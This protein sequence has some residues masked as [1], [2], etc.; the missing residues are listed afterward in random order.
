MSAVDYPLAG[1]DRFR[2]FDQREWW[3]Y[4]VWLFVGAVIA[5]GELWAAVG[6]PWWLTIS[7]TIGHLEQLWSPVKII[8]VALVVAGA[9][10]ALRYPPGRNA[11]PASSR[12][13][14]R[15]RTENGRL[16]RREGGQADQLPGLYF[17]LA[18]AVVAAAGAVTAAQGASKFTVGY[19]IYGLMAAA[20][21]VV[22]NVLAF[23]FAREVPFPTLFRTLSDLD[24]R[25]HSAVMVVV[26]GLAVLAV[27]LVAYPWP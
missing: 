21:L 10:G 8:I 26:A 24:K 15:W 27:H 20:F 1:L 17:P 25:W 23:W 16:T 5:V 9:V 22:P 11:F 3:G 12:H 2:N 6:N 19:V 4:G 18:V 7:A 13:P 14:A